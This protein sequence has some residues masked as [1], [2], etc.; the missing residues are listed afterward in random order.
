LPL[1]TPS[2][3]TLVNGFIGRYH[4]QHAEAPC[5][6]DAALDGFGGVFPSTTPKTDYSQGFHVYSV[7]ITPRLII[8]SVDGEPYYVATSAHAEGVLPWTDMY[9]IMGNQLWK[10]WNFPTELPADF[11]I[12]YVKTW[13]PVESLQS[14]DQH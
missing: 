10:G 2:Q 13:V 8:Y 1:R 9:L 14:L 12:D 6:K 5:F 4:W 7:E 11:E 3:C